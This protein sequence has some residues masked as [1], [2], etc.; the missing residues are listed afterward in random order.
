MKHD[1]LNLIEVSGPFLAVPVLD[2]AFPQG[3]DALD[4][5]RS[6]RVRRAYD[7]WRDAVDVDA[8][9]VDDVH[10]V[11]I[12]EVLSTVLDM[13]A[14]TIRRG[15]D[16]PEAVRVA[17]PE[18][19]VTLVPDLV[20]VDPSKGDAPLLPIDVLGPDV[21][22]DASGDLDGYTAT[23]A[24]RMVTM[25]RGAGCPVGLV[26][27]G[28]RWML[29]HAPVGAAASFA[30]WY[31]R[32]WGQEPETL[33]AFVSLLDVRRFYGPETERLDALHGRSLKHQDEVTEALGAQVRRA[34][35]VLV[36]S[37][38]R[39]DEDRERELLRGTE[40]RE[41]YEAA[42]TVMMRLVFLLAAEERGLLLLNDPRYDASYAL[43]TLRMQLRAEPDEVLERRRSA[44]SRM[45]ALFR[46]VYGGV[47]HPAMAMPALGGSLFDPDRYPFLEGRARGTSWRTTPAEPLPI[48]DRTVLLLLDAIQ[49]FQGRTLSYQALDVEQIGHVYEGLLERT[50]ERVGDVTLELTASA[51]AANPSVALGE[52]ESAALNGRS[53]VV[54]LLE[55]RTERSASA[56][57]NDLDRAPDESLNARVLTVCRGDLALRD[58]VLPYAHLLKTDP[59]GYPLV[60]HEGAFVVV[61]GTDRRESGTHYTPKSLTEKIVE[62]T[63]T[64]LVYDGPAEGEPREA[65]RPKGSEALLDLKVCDP[66]MGSGAFL[67]QVCRFLSE[68]LVEAWARE[69]DAGQV[70]GID[71]HVTDG[72]PADPMPTDAEERAV[73]ARRLVAERCLYG[74]DLNPLAVELAKLSLWLTT[75]SKGRPFG[76]LDHNLKSGDSLLGIRS[77]AQL[78]ELRLEPTGDRQLRLFGQTI[79]RAVEEA[80][81]LRQRL[82]EIPIR[83]IRDVEAMAALDAE[84]Q[85]ALDLPERI[86]DAFVG[87]IYA[88]GTAKEVEKRLGSLAIVAD[89]VVQGDMERR[90]EVSARAR[91]ELAFDAPGDR[92]LRPFHWSLEYPEVFQGEN[93]GFD[94][95]VGNPPFLGG[96]RISTVLG[97]AFNAW[98]STVLAGVSRNTDLV[99]HF[100]RLAFSLLRKEGAFGLLSTNTIA[101]GDTRE[102]GLDWLTQNGATIYSAHPNEPWPGAAAVSTS[103]VHVRKGGWVGSRLLAGVPTTYISAA[104]SDLR[105]S[106]PKKLSANANKSF[107]GSNL[108]G[109]GFVLDRDEA[110]LLIGTNPRNSEVIFPYLVGSDLNS[111]PE[112]SPS[113]YAINFRDWSR[114]RAMEYE[115][116]F[117]IVLE[118]VKPHRDSISDKKR[119]IKERWWIYESV[120]KALYHAI[121]QGGDFESHPKGWRRNQQTP[122]RVIAFA[123]QA[124]KYPLFSFVP[125]SITFSHALGLI[126]CSEGSILAQLSSSLHENWAF[127]Y[128]GRLETRLRYKSATCFQTFPFL[129]SPS[130]EIDSLGEHLHS[131]RRRLM[132]A[133][134]IGLTDLYNVFHDAENRNPLVESLRDV[135]R[136]IDVAILGTYGWGDLPL[137]HGFYE[138]SYL[139]DNDCVRYTISESARVEAMRRLLKL[140]LLR[141]GSAGTAPHERAESPSATASVRAARALEKKDQVA[142]F[143]HDVVPSPVASGESVFDFLRANSGWHAKSDVL[144]SV[145]LPA[146]QWSATIS[147]LV[148]RGLVE[149]KGQKRGTRYRA[150]AAPSSRTDTQ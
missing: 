60:H 80:L 147:D 19:G 41:L 84:A 6:K 131:E 18:R 130:D 7:E 133:L 127:K 11:W 103:R 136:Q 48:D 53:R 77:L 88:G 20:V 124:T 143:D 63:L 78:T 85:A 79:E 23:P 125:P 111:D 116:A 69:E 3:L 31:A 96:R 128:G 92:A 112:Q 90:Q 26:T 99:A 17:L 16:V 91:R 138:V 122:E 75:L 59:W 40:P 43:S 56:L 106:S 44:W 30:S 126:A 132:E 129:E 95:F 141:H 135:H 144:A 94:A 51:K 89:H 148:E 1:W 119:R 28:E 109:I 110:K 83:D 73:L 121:G 29:V 37:V 68:R 139:S 2:E 25:L 70:V 39:A 149:R 117:R 76:F 55:E 81:A 46:A 27:N 100:F 9:D 107:Q 52:L 34:V 113:R 10:R 150:V 22:P 15:D 145:D 137:D 86:A 105:E 104:L 32:L 14:E 65:W 58:R 62:E 4:G 93:G 72:A 47:D 66:A 38:D 8:P 140:N 97:P 71:G 5:H 142:L 13:D 24:E 74:V 82:R 50:V 49:V 98:L 87:T 61:L 57:G 134:S 108:N 35:E 36:Q 54:S 115:E 21:D 102:S 33:R 42:L 146:A 101:E 64:T 12:D 123:T 114:G 118:R 120:A 45:L 67:V